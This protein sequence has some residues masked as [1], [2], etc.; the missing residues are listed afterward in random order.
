MPS[1]KENPI[2]KVGDQ[3]WTDSESWIEEDP[4]EDLTR[5]GMADLFEV[6]DLS[7][8]EIL[9]SGVLDYLKEGKDLLRFERLRRGTIDKFPGLGISFEDPQPPEF[10]YHI[11]PTRNMKNIQRKGL[12]PRFRG[13]LSYKLDP[14]LGIHTVRYPEDAVTMAFMEF[15][16]Y[17]SK[18]PSKQTLPKIRL[19]PGME[20]TSDPK[21]EEEH[22]IYVLLDKVSLKD[23]EVVATFDFEDRDL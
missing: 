17:P 18:I 9:S 14:Y 21:F 19:R 11:T 15:L 12:L 4:R 2:F 13:G 7:E 10:V 3:S 23:I 22:P 6:E 8:E 16:R 20:I 1:N 5:Y